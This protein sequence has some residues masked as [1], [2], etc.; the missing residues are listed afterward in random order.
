MILSCPLGIKRYFPIF[1]DATRIREKKRKKDEEYIYIYKRIK[2]RAYLLVPF[3]RSYLLVNSSI[4]E[5]SSGYSSS[6][7]Q[8]VPLISRERINNKTVVSSP[9]NVA[10][11]RDLFE[12]H[13]QDFE[14]K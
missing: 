5:D 12:V 10:G 9:A 13:L 7:T 11:L 6:C 4:Y 3:P 8:L 1:K 2:A 14:C